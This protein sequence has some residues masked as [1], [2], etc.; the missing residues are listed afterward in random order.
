MVSV[1]EAE[2]TLRLDHAHKSHSFAFEQRTT[3]KFTVLVATEQQSPYLARNKINEAKNKNKTYFHHGSCP[4]SLGGNH[5]E[6]THE[7]PII[8]HGDDS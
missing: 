1:R 3:N 7:S 8:A 2:D 4:S 5:H 6:E